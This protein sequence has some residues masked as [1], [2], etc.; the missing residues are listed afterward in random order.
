VVGGMTIA[1]EYDSID[2][3][4]DHKMTVSIWEVTVSL[5]DIFSFC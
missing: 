4:D 2:M 3:E 1:T 5:W